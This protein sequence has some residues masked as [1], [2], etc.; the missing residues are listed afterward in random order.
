MPSLIRGMFFYLDMIMDV[1]SRKIVA[2]EV[3][4]SESGFHAAVLV[5]KAILSEGCLLAPP[6]LHSDNGALQKGFTLRAKLENLGV[7]A[8]YSRPHMSATITLTRR[9]CSAL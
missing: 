5:H 8:S 1:F 4:L 9:P 3:H 6:V 7:T 2:R